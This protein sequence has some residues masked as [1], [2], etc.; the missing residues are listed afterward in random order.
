MSNRFRIPTAVFL[1]CILVGAEA[2]APGI[3][4]PS[5]RNSWAAG[6]PV[7]ATAQCKDGTWSVRKL[8]SGA[9]SGHGGV[10]KFLG[11][12]F[13]PFCLLGEKRVCTLGPPPLCHCELVGTVG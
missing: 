3:N 11:K 2:L 6:R 13:V 4:T 7:D 12:G 1:A 9:C 5:F 10:A 8:R